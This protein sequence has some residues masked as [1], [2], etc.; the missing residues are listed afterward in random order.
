MLCVCD[1]FPV[2]TNLSMASRLVLI[3]CCWEQG[4][5]TTVESFGN[6]PRSEI[7]EYRPFS[8]ESR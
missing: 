8:T 4:I 5:S 2:S 6:V 7:A 1:I 3:P